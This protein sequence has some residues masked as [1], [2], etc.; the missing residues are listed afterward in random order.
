MSTKWSLKYPRLSWI[1]ASKQVAM[2]STV[3]RHRRS[4]G[5]R[6]CP[7]LACSS[8]T[9]LN[10][11]FVIYNFPDVVSYTGCPNLSE[12][13]V[14]LTYIWM[15]TMLLRFTSISAKFHS[16][17]AQLYRLSLIQI[18][19]QMGYLVHQE[20]E[21]RLIIHLPPQW[22]PRRPARRGSL[23]QFLKLLPRPTC[24]T[25]PRSTTCPWSST[26]RASGAASGAQKAPAASTRLQNLQ[27]YTRLTPCPNT[28][29]STSSRTRIR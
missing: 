10:L 14:W 26:S 6:L 22:F 16:A 17:Q 24:A 7:S 20:Q 15:I 1:R 13:R 18:S 25:A 28:A 12:T 5:S 23:S 3:R 4:C 21:H 11:V 2:P 27:P 8:L 19:D 29:W 9:G